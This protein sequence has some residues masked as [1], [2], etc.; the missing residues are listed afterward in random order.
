MRALVLFIA[1]LC[2]ELFYLYFPVELKRS[3]KTILKEITYQ[4][5]FSAWYFGTNFLIAGLFLLLL[6]KKELSD[7]DRQYILV[8]GWF[9]MSLGTIYVLNYTHIYITNYSERMWLILIYLLIVS[10]MILISAVRHGYFK[11]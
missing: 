10:M 8:E 5:L 4:D 1:H 3:N 9:F 7:L 6:R 2:S 11:K